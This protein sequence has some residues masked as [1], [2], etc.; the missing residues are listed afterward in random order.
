MSAFSLVMYIS[1]KIEVH[2]NRIIEILPGLCTWLQALTRA[3]GMK[4]QVH[5]M[6][7]E[8]SDCCRENWMD[9]LSD[10]VDYES[11][12]S[13]IVENIKIHTS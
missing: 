4:S 12:K 10:F 11:T 8:Y 3:A 7:H 1:L 5:C 9:L 2:R 13:C 6:L